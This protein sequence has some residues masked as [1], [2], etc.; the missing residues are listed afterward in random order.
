MEN[1]NIRGGC[2]ST[3]CFQLS[4]FRC[5]RFKNEVIR[6]LDKVFATDKD[7]S[8]LLKRIEALEAS[9]G[10]VLP[11]ITA[12]AETLPPSSQATANVVVT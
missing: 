4:H 2:G 5:P 11:N 7:V 1:E 6:L 10:A 3:R 12:Q 8:D 9:G